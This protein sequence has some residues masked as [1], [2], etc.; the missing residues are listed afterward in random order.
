MHL[1]PNLSTILNVT[2][3]RFPRKLQK[4]CDDILTGIT[5][6]FF[7]LEDPSTTI[8]IKPWL[9]IDKTTLWSHQG[10]LKEIPVLSYIC[11]WFFFWMVEIE[12]WKISG[13]YR[14]NLDTNLKC[15]T[16]FQ[17]PWKDCINKYQ[18][19]ATDQKP[20]DTI[21]RAVTVPKKLFR[22]PVAALTHNQ[23]L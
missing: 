4:S 2:I 5:S 7:P 8:K 21:T 22:L 12:I 9:T 18:T 14:K 19:T 17:R 15:H 20:N 10:Q 1:Q 3:T 6:T 23:N 16:H 13:T 11:I